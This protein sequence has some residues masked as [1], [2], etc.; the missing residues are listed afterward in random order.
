M[1]TLTI[2]LYTYIPS[3]LEINQRFKLFN[4]HYFMH[5]FD[6]TKNAKKCNKLIKVSNQLNQFSDEVKLKKKLTTTS[7]NISGCGMLI[8]L[9]Y[10][11]YQRI[12]KSV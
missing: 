7:K 11:K 2:G 10:I 5:M 6:L 12:C 8:V 9:I 3:D 1:I 4:L